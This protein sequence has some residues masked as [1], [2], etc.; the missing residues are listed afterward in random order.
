MKFSFPLIVFAVLALAPFASA[1]TETPSESPSATPVPTQTIAGYVTSTDVEDY[2]NNDIVQGNFETFVGKSC[3]ALAEG[4]VFWNNDPGGTYLKSRPTYTGTMTPEVQELIRYY[5][6]RDYV[7]SWVDKAFAQS[8]TTADLGETDYNNGNADF[9]T[10]FTTSD[11]I[12]TQGNQ[13]EV[14]KECIGYQESIKKVVAY[15]GGFTEIM[16]QMQSSADKI[17]AGCLAQSATN[18]CMDAVMSWDAAVA[19]FVGS[20]E[21]NGADDES[22]KP[23]GK[24]FFTLGEKRCPAYMTCGINGDTKN[25][26]D[27]ASVNLNIMQLFATGKQLVFQGQANQV[28]NIM[29]LIS[30]KLAI[31][32]I[33]G[34]M[35]YAWRQSGNGSPT[36]VNAYALTP[37]IDAPGF[38]PGTS[39]KGIGEM[40]A[41]AHLALPKLWA[42][43][44]SAARSAAAEIKLGGPSAVEG[45]VNFDNVKLAFECNYKC[46]GITCAEVG[47]LF[48]GQTDAI[49][50]EGN[51]IGASTARS[52]ACDD[53]ENNS[54]SPNPRCRRPSS[55]YRQKCNSFKGK[56]GIRYRKQ[57]KF[58]HN[59]VYTM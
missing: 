29:R 8:Q 44:K 33:Q 52:P 34:T 59:D 51:Q 26:G 9:F 2:L 28:R 25:K 47:G 1:Q 56:S 23:E 20:K 17:N 54:L 53:E 55:A 5:G 22:G 24:S 14:G 57:L 48:D 3:A 45:P 6:T 32:V 12:T 15:T 31:P 37:G 36:T 16:Q 19:V 42:C 40:V 50:A 49:D 11:V 13:V 27:I 18:S 43:S 39:D 35:R 4:Q 41:F 38:T 46:L 30:N 58:S 7:N 10:A 21:E